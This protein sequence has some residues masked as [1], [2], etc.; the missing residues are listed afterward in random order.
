MLVEIN[1]KALKM[2][3]LVMTGTILASA[4]ALAMPTKEDF[5]AAEP[6]VS[7]L[8]APTVAEF[9]AKKKTAAEVG[10]VSVQFAEK[11]ETEAA[12]YLLYKG[13]VSYL[14]RGE[15]YDK[16]AD[17][18]LALQSAIPD[19][20]AEDMAEVISRATVRATA[21]KAPRLFALYRRLKTQAASS[22]D[23]QMYERM[24]KK[25]PADLPTRRKYAEALAAAGNW[26]SSLEEFAKLKDSAAKFAKEELAGTVKAS[27]AGEFWWAYE[28]SY[29]K[30]DETFKVHAASFYRQAL[31]MG[32]VTGLKVE[33]IKRR[34]EPYVGEPST[35]L[36]G[37]FELKTGGD[38]PFTVNGNH[39][40]LTLKNGTKLEFVKCPPGKVDV[41]WRGQGREREKMGVFRYK[42]GSV[43]TLVEAKSVVNM[44]RVARNVRNARHRTEAHRV[45]NM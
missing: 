40:T 9:K 26:Q 41:A 20:P 22:S 38:S 17:A 33:L 15:E 6:I 28:S 30:A 16:A 44:E 8:M 7:E 2:K 11:A 36:Q 27:E 5:K 45:V 25:K 32:Q 14:T 42:C 24:L 4:V 10:E 21:K 23:A 39:A 12:K 34:I 31:G 37:Q 1:R 13:A 19:I 18:A 3:Q 35:I 29:E 43:L